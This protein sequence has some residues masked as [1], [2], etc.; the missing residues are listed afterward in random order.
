MKAN[1]FTL[2]E[3]LIVMGL[4]TLILVVASQLLMSTNKV[5][6]S[7]VAMSSGVNH[8]QQGANVVADDVRRALNIVA[9]GQT[10]YLSTLAVGA[11]TGG[12][13]AVT[14][15]G[16]DVL[17]LYTAKSV[18][19]RCTGPAE[20]YEYVVYYFTARSNA[21]SGSEWSTV[22]PDAR[23]TGQKVLMQFSACVTVLDPASAVTSQEML[24]VVSDYLGA[25]SFAYPGISTTGKYRRVVLSLTPKQNVLGQAVTASPITTVATARNI[26]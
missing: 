23:N 21:T 3:L 25:G 4:G 9:P 11:P 18:G 17:A 7:S 22:A 5:S 16:A 13:P 15:T 19:T 8:V 26:H 10:P 12:S 20:N 24:R 2:L 6:T 14:P 1:G